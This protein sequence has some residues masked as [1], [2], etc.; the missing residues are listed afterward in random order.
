VPIRSRRFSRRSLLLA[1]GVAGSAA[2][3]GQ[4]PCP[5]LPPPPGATI[6][7]LPAQ[8]D[9]LRAIVSTAASGT[10]ILL[11]DGFYD[12]SG[13]D[14]V[15]RLVFTTPG[16]TLR[17]FSGDRDAVV[18]DGA[19]QT[20]ELVSILAADVTVAD[21]TLRRAYD[22]P[23]HA[24]GDGSPITGVRLYNL[25]IVDP[26]QQAVKVNP[27]GEGWVDDGRLECSSL[28]LTD[29]GRAQ[30]R[31]N[32]YTGG[33]DAHAARGW[34]VRRNRITGFWCPAG[35]SEHAIHFWRGSRD[36]LVE[37]NL[38]LD[39]ARGVGFGLGA[40]G[41][42]R[43]YPDDPYPGIPYLGHVDGT[44]RANFVAAAD[45]DLFASEYGFDTGIAIEQAREVA[46]VHDT[47][48][49]TSAPFSSIEWRFADT[50]VHVANDLVSH[51]LRARDGAQATLAGNLESA[52]L[53]WFADVTAGDLHLADPG[54]PP[55]GG[56]VVL[57]AG[58]AGDDFD[59]QPRDAEPDVGADELRV[60]LF[61]D[62]FESGDTSAWSAAVP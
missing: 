45:P 60:P 56:G 5:P 55:V 34:I 19:Y 36:T 3:L 18:L 23:V 57:P 21:L 2:A 42:G 41:T 29:A 33:I 43:T 44:I 15:S 58:T 12:M 24:S 7:V 48:A 54:A 31:D 22:H 30:I 20:S 39:C 14:A 32:C 53:A 51:N 62:G 11:H 26:G 49:S 9:D 38:I 47:V 25:R 37:G 10:T 28:E 46:V 8:A 50:L 4:V 1:A 40:T 6:E 16:V 52:P 13:G 27:I 35:L 61:A 17:S 59:G